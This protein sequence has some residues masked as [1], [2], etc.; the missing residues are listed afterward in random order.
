MPAVSKAQHRAAVRASVINAAIDY[1]AWTE[2]DDQL[3]DIVD[4]WLDAKQAPEA[5]RDV[6]T[7]QREKFAADFAPGSNTDG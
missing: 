3:L 2:L 7:K 1:G 5:D 4:K 6:L